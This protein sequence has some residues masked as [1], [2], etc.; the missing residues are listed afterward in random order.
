MAAKRRD[1]GEGSYWKDKH[2]QWWAK[3][4]RGGRR[5]RA[6]AATRADAKAKAVALARELALD[7]SSDVA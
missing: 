1:K 7:L 4:E 2:G 5:L 6:R 3:A